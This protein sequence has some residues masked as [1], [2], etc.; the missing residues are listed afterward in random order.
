MG[1]FVRV[2]V[3]VVVGVFVGVEVGVIVGSGYLFGASHELARDIRWL[4]IAIGIAL[5]VLLVIAPL[6]M[7]RQIEHRQAA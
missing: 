2:A 7:K 4:E 3:G 6:A 1:V 5:V